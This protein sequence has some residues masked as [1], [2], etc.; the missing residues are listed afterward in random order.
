M[1]ENA[2]MTWDQIVVKPLT[3]ERWDDLEQ[4]FGKSGAY[5][6]CW[7]MWWR[8]TRREF[9]ANGNRGN[10]RALRELVNDGVVPGVLA[11]HEK[12]PVAWCSVAPREQFGS[13]NRSP[14]LKRLDDRQVW[15]IVCF[16]IDREYRQ[17][18][19]A[20]ALLSKVIGYVHKQG[21]DCIEAYPT[22]PRGEKLPDVS[23]FM[24]VPSLFESAGFVEV[25]HPSESKQ[26]MRYEVADG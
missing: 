3:P 15:S 14:V 16:F 21:G 12:N 10:R 25:A 13:L 6:G 17:R 24:G 22:A 5:G 19:L 4:L 26:I 2:Q 11:Y 20:K 18:G 9:E 1:S 8:I 23:S 7:C